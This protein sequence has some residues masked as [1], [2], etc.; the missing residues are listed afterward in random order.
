MLTLVQSVCRHNKRYPVCRT[1]LARWVPVPPLLK[2][3]TEPEVP[4][5]H[6]RQP[7][8]GDSEQRTCHQQV[9]ILV[10]IILV[11]RILQAHS[12]TKKCHCFHL[13]GFDVDAACEGSAADKEVHG[14]T[15]VPRPAQAGHHHHHHHH[16]H[17]IIITWC[18]CAGQCSPRR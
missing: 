15:G 11:T 8:G 2:D 9:Y 12:F 4:S 1:W 3:C 13:C 14:D 16:H 17:I 7:S 10:D 5:C 6:C 18:R